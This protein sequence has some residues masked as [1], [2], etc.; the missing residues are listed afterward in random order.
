MGADGRMKTLYFELS[1]EYS[2]I[3]VD[4]TK[5]W[6]RYLY[7]EYIRKIQNVL[8]AFKLLLE[9][10]NIFLVNND[11]HIPPPLHTY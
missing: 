5:Q 9:R 1:D 2:K 4:E 10:M 3:Y 11:F 7:F 6:Q 8:I